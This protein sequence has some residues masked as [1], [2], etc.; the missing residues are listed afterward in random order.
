MIIWF[1]FFVEDVEPY[2]GQLHQ[3]KSHVIQVDEGSDQ[4]VKLPIKV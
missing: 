3:G 4:S 2:E 1:S